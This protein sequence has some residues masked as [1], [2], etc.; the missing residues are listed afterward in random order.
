MYG[1]SSGRKTVGLER[2]IAIRDSNL[3]GNSSPLKIHQTIIKSKNG[4]RIDG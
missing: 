4:P 1:D 3:D 2:E